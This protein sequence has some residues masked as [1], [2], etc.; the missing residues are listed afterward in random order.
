MYKRYMDKDIDEKA[1]RINGVMG[2]QWRK[3][4]KANFIYENADPD[5]KVE[6]KTISDARRFNQLN[7]FKMFLGTIINDPTANI[8]QA[9]KK[10]GKLMGMRE[11]E[12]EE[13]LPLTP[14]EMQAR[15]ENKRLQNDEKVEVMETD[16]HQVHIFQ[17]NMLPDNPYKFAHINAHKRAL[18]LQAHTPELFPRLQPSGI[19][20]MAGA[21]TGEQLKTPAKDKTSKPTSSVSK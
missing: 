6:S 13:V 7:M 21:D 10:M 16:D 15:D 5:V 2:A 4:T 11:D 14:Q 20:P 17:H 3:L 8:R 18:L 19:N 9:E 1:V 12:I